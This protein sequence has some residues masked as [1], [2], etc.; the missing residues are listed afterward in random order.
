MPHVPTV[1]GALVH[2]RPD[3]VPGWSSSL[4]GVKVLFATAELAPLA[5]VGGLA[6]A[7]AGYVAELRR[8]G[9]EVEVVM[10]DYGDVTVT[11]QVSIELDVADWAAPAT[12]RHGHVAGVGD[13]TLVAVPGMA[14]AHP[15]QQ[16]D[17]RGWPDNDRRFFA[18]S[19]GVAALVELRS[20]DL[21]HLNDW[22]TAT[23]L[24]HLAAPPP[25]VLTIH[26][27]GYQ[28]DAHLGWLSVFPH[29][30]ELYEL[31]GDCNPLVGAI[32]AADLVVAVSP[33]YATE[34]TTAAGGFGADHVLRAKGDR[35]VGILNGIDTV[36]WDPLA[37]PN[38]GVHYDVSD[39][40]PKVT[41]RDELLEEFSLTHGGGP[42]M[43]M[44]TRLAEQKGVDLV[45]PTIPFLHA[46]NARLVVLGSGDRGLAESLDSAAALHP[47]VVG[48]RDGYDEGL[49]HRMF[50]GA[51]VFVMPSRFE[52][53]GLAQ[54]QAMRYGTLPLVTDVGGLHDTV[55]DV[56][57]VPSRG[58]GI[59]VGD[60]TS[61]AVLDGMHRMARALGQSRR[62]QAMQ[63]RGMT[64]DWSWAQP[65]R[66]HI[67]WYER[68]VADAFAGTVR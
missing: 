49:A 1:I 15:Y 17:G 32:R 60:A 52:P 47:D 35:L 24:A 5:R 58:T 66:A 46:L 68:L 28:G 36:E 62:R 27:L 29:R 21:V 7:A 45:L 57:R 20:P 4:R 11:N 2:R 26:T 67:E 40:D 16:P 54:M 30:A 3:V 34:I 13:V 42:V 55:V 37:D 8:Q 44:V 63:R 25:A 38:L 31:R 18:F 59:V 19:A 6:S 50:A 10:P 22:H 48:F 51:D 39:L 33:N 9:V 53:C 65:A 43:V 41:L 61:L 14:R 64:A 56:D 12:A 23:T